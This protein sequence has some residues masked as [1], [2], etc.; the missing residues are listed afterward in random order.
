MGSAKSFS[1]N[2]RQ[3]EYRNI[4]IAC[5]LNGGPQN[6]SRLARSGRADRQAGLIRQS[7]VE[8]GRCCYSMTVSPS[9]RISGGTRQ[10]GVAQYER[11]CYHDVKPLGDRVNRSFRPQRAAVARSEHV[12]AYNTRR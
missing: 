3:S 7:Y 1:T 6:R 10:A 4:D 8:I 11:P 12:V 2:G 5:G 9:T